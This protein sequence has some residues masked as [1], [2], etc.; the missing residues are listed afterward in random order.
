MKNRYIVL[1]LM[2]T[3]VVLSACET[4]SEGVSRPTFYPVFTLNGDEEMFVTPGDP[5]TEPGA[6]A[7]EEGA[8]IET[9]VSY[10]GTYF[11]GNVSSIDTDVP[12]K[13]T[14]TYSAV[15]KDG[16]PGTKERI[17]YVVGQGDLVNSIEG[18]YTSTVDRVPAAV[19]AFDG[20]Y[21]N[22]EY[23]LIAK[24]GANT[25]VLSDVIG[26]YYDLPLGRGFGAGYAGPGATVTANNIP[27]NNFTFGPAV[28][29]GAFGGAAEIKSMV[30]NATAKTIKFV[31]EWDGG[32]YTFTVT[33]KQVQL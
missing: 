19:P 31:T 25:Y 14:V 1:M 32:P 29:V 21:Q 15:N 26:G 5:Y 18:L 24:T 33:L 11:S 28:A 17:V 30:V 8:E 20:Q 13:Y 27:A 12:D 9:S 22:M 2:A 6:T 7:Q 3:F 16:F 23:V 4:D 10:A